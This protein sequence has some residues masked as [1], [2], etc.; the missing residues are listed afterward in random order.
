MLSANSRLL[1]A[2]ATLLYLPLT[3]GCRRLRFPEQ[4]ADY[5]EYAYVTSGDT[6][7]VSVL[8]LVNMRRDRVLQVGAHP[9]GATANPRRNEVYVVN[10]GADGQ[11]G[12]LS[13]IDTANNATVATI[14]LHMR[15]YEIAVAPDGRRGYVANSGSNTISVIDL[16]T[17]RELTTVGT[18]EAPGIARLSA[19]GHTLVVSNRVSGSVSIYSITDAPAP[20]LRATFDH[21]AGAT[22]VAIIPLDASQPATKAFVACSESDSVLAVG[23]AQPP[24]TWNARQDPAS[25]A[26][27]LLTTLRVGK[28]PVQFAVKPD[29]GEIFSSNFGSN[30]ISEIS[31]WTNEVG[32]TYRIGTQPVRGIVA[33]DNSTLWV[34]NFGADSLSIYSIDDGRLAGSVRT[35][36]APDA[37]AMSSD[38]HVLLAANSRSGDVAVIRTRD[39]NGPELFTMLP[40]GSKPNAIAVKAFRVG[41]KK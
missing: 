32:G 1:L 34:S 40:V 16:Q 6:G 23:L 25:A 38:E 20:T 30:T 10:T 8:D 19:D 27:H 11:N 17:R 29:G 22:D 7:T 3:Y 28:S 24:G 35:G 14:P 2:C 37:I 21:C 18:G 12:S 33:A 39:N 26:D 13:V 36:A 9:T 31:T 41:A 15:P 5:R 4:P